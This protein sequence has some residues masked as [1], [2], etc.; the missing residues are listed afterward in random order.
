MTSIEVLE[1]RVK[2]NKAS[3]YNVGSIVCLVGAFLAILMPDTLLS[4]TVSGFLALMG[5][6]LNMVVHGL[7][8]DGYSRKVLGRLTTLDDPPL[9]QWREQ[10]EDTRQFSVGGD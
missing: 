1:Y 10:L 6:F 5:A 9:E 2:S 8:S 4:L 3:I 7:M